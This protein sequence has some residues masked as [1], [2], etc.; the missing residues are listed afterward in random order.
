MAADSLFIGSRQLEAKYLS[1]DTCPSVNP[2]GNSMDVHL[3][4]SAAE[5]S[6]L[7][8][9]LEGTRA[10]MVDQLGI[11]GDGAWTMIYSH[12]I[13]GGVGFVRTE[14]ITAEPVN[15]VG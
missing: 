1:P 14:Q 8:I 10:Q 11:W 12:D 13:P 15:G 6:P 7:L 9:R 2:Y 4:P 3:L 5:D